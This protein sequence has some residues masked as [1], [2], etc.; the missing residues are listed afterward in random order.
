VILLGTSRQTERQH[1]SYLLRLHGY[2]YRPPEAK[3][4]SCYNIRTQITGVGKED[5]NWIK[6][7]HIISGGRFL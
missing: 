7:Y 5:V 6:L 1:D 4:C 2:G 3:I